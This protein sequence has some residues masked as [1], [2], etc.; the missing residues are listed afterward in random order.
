MPFEEE[1]LESLEDD[2]EPFEAFLA[3]NPDARRELMNQAGH[4]LRYQ[5]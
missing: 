4:R 1:L 3:R 2:D 5:F